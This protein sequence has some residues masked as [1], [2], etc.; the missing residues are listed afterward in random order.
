[1][2]TFA[3]Q[4][5]ESSRTFAGVAVPAPLREEISAWLL[6]YL[7]THTESI[8]RSLTRGPAVSNGQAFYDWL[9]AGIQPDWS[10]PSNW[11]EAD[12][13][14][15]NALPCPLGYYRDLW[16]ISAP[17]QPIVPAYRARQI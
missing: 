11:A 17:L 14:T 5:R 15:L 3:R 7:Q 16:L 13:A 2:L 8:V 1:M 6:D 4:L 9:E 12:A 10:H